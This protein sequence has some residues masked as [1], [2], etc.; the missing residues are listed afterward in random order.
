M[1]QLNRL[2]NRLYEKQKSS[3]ECIIFENSFT[4]KDLFTEIELWSQKLSEA[5]AKPGF[6][7][8][9]NVHNSVTFIAV[10]LASWKLD[11]RVLIL[12]TRLKVNEVEEILSKVNPHIMISSMESPNML[13]SFMEKVTTQIECRHNAPIADHDR[14]LLLTSSGST[15]APK[16]IG[17]SELS[18]YEELVRTQKFDGAIQES[19]RV[20]I[21]NSISYAY[22]FIAGVLQTLYV[23][24][25]LIF[26]TNRTSDMIHAI[27]THGVTVLLGVPSQY[28]MINKNH[29]SIGEH[30]IRVAICA[31]ESLSELIQHDWSHKFGIPV[32]QMYGMSEMGTISVDMLG[33]NPRSVG[34]V[35]DDIS[36]K[37][38]EDQ[39]WIRTDPDP[40]L[41][42]SGEGRYVDGW[43]RTYD[44]GELDSSYL[45][46]KGRFDSLVIING[47]KVH[48]T[49]IE[50]TLKLMPQIEEVYA[51]T[52]E[53]K[54]IV[55]M[56]T[57]KEGFE[58]S[59]AL[60]W[61][62]ER[63]ANYK[64]PRKYFWVRSL[65]KT[66]SGKLARKDHSTLEFL[67]TL[68]VI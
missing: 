65:P 19:D 14:I 3:K 68:E 56:L 52:N 55:V 37:I 16:I 64:V 36:I 25:T 49:E 54:Q 33:I 57:A 21:L 66:S 35:A 62:R 60:R 1:N 43:L 38:V 5:G 42:H 34:K 59:E 58:L 61:C 7:F 39:I 63:L 48:L 8:A 29:K 10:I 51:K 53:S 28:E 23:G 15:G 30:H 40:Y 13:S 18:L 4:Y 6:L 32:G 20:L 24:G 12:D 44:C 22:G 31:G 50:H 47:L 46:V 9:V 2:L 11:C 26:S 67:D 17:R 45:H 27:T 41:Y